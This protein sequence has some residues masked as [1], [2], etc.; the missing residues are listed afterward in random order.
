MAQHAQMPS[1]RLAF[2]VMLFS[3]STTALSQSFIGYMTAATVDARISVEHAD[4]YAEAGDLNELFELPLNNPPNVNFLF[5]QEARAFAFANDAN[6]FYVGL[7]TGRSLGTPPQARGVEGYVEVVYESPIYIKGSKTPGPTTFT[8]TLSYLEIKA[9]TQKLAASMYLRAYLCSVDQILLLN[10]SGHPIFCLE[11]AMISVAIS[12]RNDVDSDPFTDNHTYKLDR[13]I[14]EGDGLTPGTFEVSIRGDIVPSA[15]GARYELPSR[16]GTFHLGTILSGERFFFRYVLVAN[17]DALAEGGTRAFIGDPLDV[18]PGIN[19]QIGSGIKL[20]NPQPQTSSQLCATNMVSISPVNRFTVLPNGTVNDDQTGLN[21]PRC[22]QG[23]SLDTAGSAAL[24]DDTCL[25]SGTITFT[26]GAALQE[27]LDA[28]ARADH[29]NA[30]WRIPNAKELATL[31]ET[32]CS[33]PAMN[34]DVFPQVDDAF[35]WTSTPSDFDFAFAVNFNSGRLDTRSQT[36]GP[37]GARLVRN[38]DP[39]PP[40][41]DLLFADDFEGNAKRGQATNPRA[42]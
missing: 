13:A 2:M 7:V 19:M 21:W 12:G 32:A 36:V 11:Q 20:A 37:G 41:Q 39:T 6:R 26:W 17:G 25:E 40:L 10:L 5:D 29:G 28:A 14:F 4:V 15:D 24:E 8:T 35:V 34:T 27:A 31:V 16:T 3:Y 33:F 23:Y 1:A 18:N 22:P 9:A 42:K 30:D 38:A